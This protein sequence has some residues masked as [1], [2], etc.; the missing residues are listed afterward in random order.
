M[1]IKRYVVREM[2]EAI[3]LIKQDLGPEAVIVSSYR[4]PSKGLAGLFMPKML[5]VTAAL[6]EP[7]D[8][9]R[10]VMKT[11]LRIAASG[12][13]RLNKQITPAVASAATAPAEQEAT[14]SQ[15]LML[16]EVWGS[17][18]AS[19]EHAPDG[20]ARDLSP[21]EALLNAR[22]N[23]LIPPAK[24]AES[25]PEALP[26]PR[27]VE[28]PAADP[29][30]EVPEE[31]LPA[32]SQDSVFE[33]LMKKEMTETETETETETGAE[34]ET[35]KNWRDSLLE[36][37]VDE[38]IVNTL[39]SG[40]AN[41]FGPESEGVDNGYQDIKRRAIQLME[42]AYKPAENT[43]VLTFVGPAGVGKTTT[44]AKIATLLSMDEQKK[45]A[46]I[47]VQA[48]RLGAS[49]QLQVFGEFL[50]I[51]VDV[52]MTPEELSRALEKH[53]DKDYIL[54]DTAGRNASNSGLLLELKS[55][56][57]TVT[58]PQEVYLVLSL[59][60][61]NRDLHRNIHEFLRVGCTKMIF[62]K[63]DETDTY[64]SL[65][66]M[67]VTP[68]LPVAYLTDGQGIPDCINEAGPKSMAD[69]LLRGMN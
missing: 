1:K 51:P 16:P 9:G 42:P 43:K 64:G 35:V 34:T 3:K 4:V 41:N 25:A 36:M 48:Y 23:D 15:R 31:K 17:N 60:T 28:S 67:V 65:L 59:T 44:L 45:L 6:D 8:L 13:S 11:P 22:L 62:T 10:R 14:G 58:E 52:V 33:L 29:V 12:G 26:R 38:G 19:N 61:K 46:L 53:S 56:I 69:L 55:F 32:V 66:N 57:K 2:Y 24:P 68:G 39:L 37:D 49:E 40:I 50:N 54:I 7:A 20:G 21:A 18:A 5:E 30:A 27:L 47:A 63:V